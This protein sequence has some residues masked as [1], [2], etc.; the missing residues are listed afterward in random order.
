M[1]LMHAALLWRAG[2]DVAVLD[3]RP[4]R[5]QRLNA[6]GYLVSGAA[7]EFHA[8]VP[9]SARAAEVGPRD[10]VVMMV[11]AYDTGDAIANSTSAVSE[12]GVVLTLQNGLGNLEVLQ[13]AFGAERVLGGTT[14]SGAYRAGDDQVVVAGVGRIALG[15]EDR[16]AAERV[17]ELF[18]AA[19]LPAEVS[20]DVQAILWTKAIVNA[21][22][23]P[24]GALTRLRN[25]QLLETPELRMLMGRVVH[26]ACRVALAAGVGPGE[27]AVAV[28]EDV[29]RTT[30]NNRC[31]MLQDLAAGR[32]TEID[33]INGYIGS[34][35]RELGCPCPVNMMLKDL[36]AAVRIRRGN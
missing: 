19:G 25:G 6:E 11:K 24:L 29:A 7:G 16:C 3:H 5:A 2:L 22:I 18:G 31:S 9:V 35:G 33:Y 20:D 14:A 1:G 23:N 32:P 15:G 21:A 34:L 10:L 4:D 28:V 13:E 12:Q 30:A 8:T 36:V 17:C 27:D 26:E